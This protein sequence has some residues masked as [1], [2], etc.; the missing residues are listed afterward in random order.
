MRTVGARELKQH[1]GE[2]IGQVQQ[3]ERFVL[4][5]RCRPV[6]VIAPLDRAALDEALAREL[7]KTEAKGWLAVAESAFAFWDN[8]EDAVWDQAPLES[9]TARGRYRPRAVPV[10]GPVWPEVPARPRALPG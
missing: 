9:V 5:V 7:A 6:A 1:T 3:G 8:D 4:T 2:I 10:H